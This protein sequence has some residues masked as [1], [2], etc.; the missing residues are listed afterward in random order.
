MN[1]KITI[2]MFAG[3]QPGFADDMLAAVN[4]TPTISPGVLV[5]F[6]AMH[7]ERIV[8]Q[9]IEV[10]ANRQPRTMIPEWQRSSSQGAIALAYTVDENRDNGLQIPHV[11]SI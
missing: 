11:T 5:G 3:R 8:G 4:A 10:L 6:R 7:G 1:S 2:P 9:C